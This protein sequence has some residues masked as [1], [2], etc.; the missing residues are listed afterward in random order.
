MTESGKP[1]SGAM[2]SLVK[3][4]PESATVSTKETCS[5]G[6]AS[7][8][9]GGSAKYAVKITKKGYEDYFKR[10]DVFCKLGIPCSDCKPMLEVNMV[11]VF[12]NKS[13]SLS[14]AATD[15]LG[16]N[17][18]EAQVKISVKKN[19]GGSVASGFT[20]ISDLWRNTTEAWREGVTQFGTY[21][22]EVAAPQFLPASTTVEVEEGT[23]CEH[24]SVNVNITLQPKPEEFPCPKANISVLV[25]DK[26]VATTL[27]GARVV[28]SYQVKEFVCCNYRPFLQGEELHDDV[29]NNEGRVSLL[30]GANGNY[31]IEVSKDGYT[32]ETST[33]AIACSKTNCSVSVGRICKLLH[34]I[35]LFRFAQLRE[36]L[37]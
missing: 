21:T 31:E 26:L 13:V 27:P 22:V 3:P 32:P 37:G 8:L 36:R 7:F 35:H 33:V 9:V 25:R 24:R 19:K 29:A 28:I 2:V 34:Y 15:H 4:A 20:E 1:V 11:E 30:I 10:L 18:T 17:I 23:A 16:N 6:M 14:V 12:C 5:K